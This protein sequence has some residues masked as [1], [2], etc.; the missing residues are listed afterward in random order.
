MATYL[1]MCVVYE[2]DGTNTLFRYSKCFKAEQWQTSFA[3]K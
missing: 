2:D 1:M 3:E